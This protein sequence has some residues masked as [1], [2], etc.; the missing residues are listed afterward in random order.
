VV[1]PLVDPIGNI[2]LGLV[3][4]S[5]EFNSEKLQDYMKSQMPMYMVPKL[6]KFIPVFP[7]NTNGKTDRKELGL[8]FKSL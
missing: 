2:E 4:E 1:V 5:S 3:I 8:I 6:I 7:L